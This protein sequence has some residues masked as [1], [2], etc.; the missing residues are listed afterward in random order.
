VTPM[1]RSATLDSSAS[2]ATSAADGDTQPQ[3]QRALRSRQ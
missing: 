2:V 3:H 1:V